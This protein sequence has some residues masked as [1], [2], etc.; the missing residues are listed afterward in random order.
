MPL[1]ME[2]EPPTADDD[3]LRGDRE[4]PPL[5]DRE[6][7]DEDADAVAWLPPAVPEYVGPLGDVGAIGAVD[8]GAVHREPDI[9]SPDLTVPVEPPIG[10]IG[11]VFD[12]CP[13]I[14]MLDHMFVPAAPVPSGDDDQGFVAPVHEERVVPSDAVLTA[15]EGSGCLTVVTTI[16]ATAMAATA[17]PAAILDTR[18]QVWGCVRTAALCWATTSGNVRTVM[19]ARPISP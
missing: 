16:G 10:A 2:E 4:P 3:P 6:P 13:S 18:F 11:P 8:V 17:T 15:V 1:P 5:V 14:H 12:V 9:V 19:A 7:Q